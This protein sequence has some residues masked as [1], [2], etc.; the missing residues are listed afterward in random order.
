MQV[1]RIGDTAVT[2]LEALRR[3]SSLRA[4]RVADLEPLSRATLERLDLRGTAVESLA[5]LQVHQW[6]LRRLA[7]DGSMVHALGR[8]DAMLITHLVIENNDRADAPGPSVPTGPLQAILYLEEIVLVAC[9]VEDLTPLIRHAK[10]RRLAV[11]TST[12]AAVMAAFRAARPDVE[13]VDSG[14]M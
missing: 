12:P 7:V 1:L 10:L 8:L 3:M 11:P 9:D 6:S 5:P 2:N 13:L 4:T 14:S